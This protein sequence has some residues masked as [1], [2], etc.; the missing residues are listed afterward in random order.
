VAAVT[1][2]RIE[3]YARLIVER[4]LDV[5]P[6][7]QVLIR[8]TPLSRP[9]L[10]E[11]V[12][13]IGRRGAYPLIRMGFTLWPTDIVWAEEAP[14]EVL[15]RMPDVDVY[16]S[17]HMDARVTIDAPENTR[18]GVSLPPEKIAAMSRRAAP[19]FRR[20]M[21][22]EIPWM[23]C[24][25]P[26]PALAQE[27]GMATEDFADFLF[28]AVVRDWDTE[29]QRMQR[30][31]DRFDAADEVRLVGAET[32]LRLSLRGRRGSVDAGEAN[33][34]GGEFYF[35]PNEHE[36]EGVISFLE[37]PSEYGGRDVSGARLVFEGGRVVD[38]RADSGEDVLR[39]ALDADEG[40]RRVGELG[41]GCNPGITRYM[42]NTLFD[43]K[44]DG[45]VHIAV[46]AAYQDVGG[47]NQSTVHWDLVKDMR[48]PG[49]RIEL[50]G[51]VVQQE[52][53]WL[54]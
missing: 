35:A 22:N 3:A 52:G 34:P 53:R 2:P 7:M 1:D 11:I 15:E 27:A 19:F 44:I 17:E 20:T 51:E 23:S 54:I 10:E 13:L 50:D 24:Q 12:R 40:A 28:G 41:I 46:G 14:L 25:F 18:S 39:T 48:L 6:G 47:T 21:S 43:E 16:A 31:L 5:Q 29:K 37:F 45:T 33:L 26:T 8:T 4:A 38:A 32:D 49:A 9:L 36:T 30:L 42:R